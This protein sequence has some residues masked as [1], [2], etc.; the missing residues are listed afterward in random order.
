MRLLPIL[1]VNDNP[2]AAVSVLFD[3]HVNCFHPELYRFTSFLSR[4]DIFQNVNCACHHLRAEFR[5]Q[6]IVPGVLYTFR[7]PDIAAQQVIAEAGAVCLAETVHHQIVQPV[8]P[9]ASFLITGMGLTVYQAK[10]HQCTGTC[11]A[12][13]SLAHAAA[14]TGTQPESCLFRDTAFF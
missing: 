6:M 8:C 11:A 7:R 10:N 1:F 14:E 3:R 4:K 12:Y 13:V 2:I 5:K 9:Q